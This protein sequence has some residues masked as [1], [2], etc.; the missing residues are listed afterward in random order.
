MGQPADAGDAPRPRALVVDPSE[1][2]LAFAAEALHSFRP[3]FDVAT[4]LGVEQAGEWLDTFHPDLLLLGA[5]LD[6]E[7]GRQFAARLQTDPRTAR[8]RVVRAASEPSLSELLRQVRDALARPGDDGPLPFLDLATPHRA[9]REEILEAWSGLLERGAFVGGAEV[10]GFEAEFATFVGTASAV[11]VG[12]GTDALRLALEAAGVARG[13]E[14]IVPA[15]TFIAT[16]EAVTQAGG[17]PVFA[18][19]DEATGALDPQAARRAITPRTRAI[20]PVHLYGQ[21]ADV[22]PLAALAAECGAWLIEDAAQAHG[23]RYRG[24]AAGA[25]GRAAAFSFYPGKNLGACGEAGAV[26]TSEP[27]LAERVRMLRDHGQVEKYR[28]VCEGTNARLDA[29][30]AAALRIKLRRLDA[31][32]ASRR[33]VAAW[34][35]ERLAGGA[36]RLPEELPDRHHVYHLYVVRHPERERLREALAAAGIGCGLHYPV[37][38]HLQPAYAALGHQPGDFPVAERWAAQCLSLPI[39]PE[40]TEAQVERVCRVLRRATD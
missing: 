14:V 11:G 22:A 3:G 27:A 7:A 10:E 29:L 24:V 30:Q 23:A 39:F 6:G 35:G 13:D 12:S 9:L 36:L 8:C 32:N 37:P 16:A 25:L 21:T 4:A 19:V 40:M 1:T 38:L 33:R 2:F 20:V 28:H 26:T 5:A 17:R 34:Y 31:G 18:D 15:H